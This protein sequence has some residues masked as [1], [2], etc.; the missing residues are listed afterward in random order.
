MQ[1]FKHAKSLLY[2]VLFA[3]FFWQLQ[4]AVTKLESGQLISKIKYVTQEFF[5]MPSFTVCHY[6]VY[7]DVMLQDNK[8]LADLMAEAEAMPLITA[9]FTYDDSTFKTASSV[10]W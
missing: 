7:E 6:Q 4:M 1:L 9:V 8:T 10:Q 3:L 2:A 5:D